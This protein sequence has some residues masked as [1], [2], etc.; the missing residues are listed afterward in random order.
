MSIARLEWRHGRG[1]AFAVPPSPAASPMTA[2]PVAA[3]QLRGRLQVRGHGAGQRRLRL[4]QGVLPPLQCLGNR[5]LAPPSHRRPVRCAF[6]DLLS[7]P[8][9]RRPAFAFWAAQSAEF[10][11]LGLFGMA[12]NRDGGQLEVP[13]VSVRFPAEPQINL[14]AWVFLV[15]GWRNLTWSPCGERSGG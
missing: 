2:P 14:P 11:S 6:L 8:S 4:E 3:F 12:Y 13:T 5:L 10:E 15:C 7:P 1:R 9:H